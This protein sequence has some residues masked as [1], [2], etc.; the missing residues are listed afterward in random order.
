M[1]IQSNS[2]LRINILNFPSERG[3]CWVHKGLYKQ[4]IRHGE[5]KSHNDH[6]R[7]THPC[8]FMKGVANIIGY[9]SQ[10]KNI[11]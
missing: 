6:F 10:L 3:F 2:G 8:D 4:F 7:Y 5:K 1:S 11:C 9:Y